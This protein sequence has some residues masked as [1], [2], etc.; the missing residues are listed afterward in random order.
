MKIPFWVRAAIR[1]FQVIPSLFSTLLLGELFD[2]RNMLF[3]SNVFGQFEFFNM[4]TFR[5]TTVIALTICDNSARPCVS[6]ARAKPSRTAMTEFDVMPPRTSIAQTPA[7][8]A[9]TTLFSVWLWLFGAPLRVSKNGLMRFNNRGLK[10][11]LK[12]RKVDLV[13][14]RRPSRIQCLKS[15]SPFLQTRATPADYCRE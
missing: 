13:G 7:P 2:P 12:A 1:R 4:R 15:V 14:P 6:S 10:L 11:M 8:V 3:T 5:S 9:E